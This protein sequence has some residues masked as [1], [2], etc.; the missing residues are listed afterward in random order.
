MIS[1]VKP[2]GQYNQTSTTAL[3]Y[4]EYFLVTQNLKIEII[5]NKNHRPSSDS[6][7][8]FN[9][10]QNSY[11][12]YLQYRTPV[13]LTGK[14][15]R[16][17]FSL[18]LPVNSLFS[19][20]ISSN[21]I[22][23]GTN[24]FTLI[25]STNNQKP[26]ANKE[27]GRYIISL[28]NHAV[29][30]ILE[31]MLGQPLSSPLQFTPKF[32]LRNCVRQSITTLINAWVYNLFCNEHA[33]DHP[34]VGMHFEQLVISMLLVN[35]PHNYSTALSSTVT[36]PVSQDVKRVLEYVHARLHEPISMP[37][38]IKI[39]GVPG[40][41]LFAHFKKFIGKSP[42]TYVSEK[43][44]A[45]VRDDLLNADLTDT[46]TTCA[47]RWGFT[48]L[49]R[50]SGLYRKTYGELPKETLQRVRSGVKLRQSKLNV[51]NKKK[52]TSY[53]A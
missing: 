16:E 49:G 13:E 43:R 25:S 7:V 53:P 34:M 45:K 33:F 51:N 4:F 19:I 12:S 31:S 37:E 5:S 15:A 14:S 42:L 27:S 41:S 21:E 22:L 44:L 1:S 29:V 3:S 11:N 30:D 38:L 18:P 28:K 52:R 26:V 2:L 6:V 47:T 23:G 36:P 9:H 39:S 48:N 50:F 46:V 40:S 10:C 35:Q 20:N 24:N 17:N 32:E 8:N